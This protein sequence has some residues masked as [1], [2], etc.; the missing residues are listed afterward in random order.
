MTK[1]NSFTKA[2]LTIDQELEIAEMAKSAFP[3]MSFLT[4][5]LSAKWYQEWR[6]T[7]PAHK[8]EREELHDKQTVLDEMGVMIQGYIQ[9]GE[10]LYAEMQEQNSPEAKEKRR[11]DEQ[12]FGLDYG[13]E[14][15]S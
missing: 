13:Q 14:V 6:R 9:R 2:S 12:G 1:E 8:N 15:A 5:T 11:L 3:F 10:T 4:Q 7:D